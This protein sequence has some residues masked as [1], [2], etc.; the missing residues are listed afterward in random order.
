VKNWLPFSAARDSGAESVL[1]L[2]AVAGEQALVRNDTSESL[3]EVERHLTG[4]VFLK[5]SPLSS[6]TPSFDD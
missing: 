2:A 5:A 4:V 1:F 6:P 3:A